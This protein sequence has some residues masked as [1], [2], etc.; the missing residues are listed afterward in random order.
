M[1]LAS[2]KADPIGDVF[3]IAMENHNWT[4]PAAQLT[5][6]P[7]LGNSAAPYI[8]GLV[9]PGN[10]NAA[11]VSYAANYTNAGQGVHPS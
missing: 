10:P 11:Q 4:Q 3:V 7:I 8:N 9:T 5:P 6:Q 2:A 1:P